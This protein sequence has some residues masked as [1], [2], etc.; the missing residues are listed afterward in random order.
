MTV[1]EFISSTRLLIEDVEVPEETLRGWYEA[2][3]ETEIALQP[4][5]RVP[6]SELPV[7]PDIEGWLIAVLSTQKQ[8]RYWAVLALQRLYLFS[9]IS[10]VEPCDAIAL[11]GKHVHALKSDVP[12]RDRFISDMRSGRCTC[13]F[14]SRNLK[15]RPDFFELDQAFEVSQQTSTAPTMLSRLSKPR[16]RL[17]LVAETPDLTEKWVNLITCGPS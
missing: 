8:H 6:F 13:S 11:K 7:Q 14:V 2:V 9:D 5:P 10:D 1:E 4:L 16:T 12:A 17:V 3:R 15:S